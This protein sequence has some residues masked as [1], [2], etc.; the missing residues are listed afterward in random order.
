MKARMLIPRYFVKVD[1]EEP[2]WQARYYDFN[3]FSEQKL[4][5]KVEYMHNN[6][7]RAG[8]VSEPLGW[9]WSS[10]RFWTFGKSVGIPISWPP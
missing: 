10:A 4:R 1:L 7:V 2:I 5:E 6:P 8:L 9:P 3:I